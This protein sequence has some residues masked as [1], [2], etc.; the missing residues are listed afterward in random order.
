MDAYDKFEEVNSLVK[1]T[2][3]KHKEANVD[4]VVNKG[5]VV[6]A[7]ARALNVHCAMT[8]NMINAE[9][10]LSKKD[11]GLIDQRLITMTSVAEDC[12]MLSWAGINFGD[13]DTYKLQHSIKKLSTLSGGDQIRF[14]GKIMGK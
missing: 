9:Y 7:E 6:T 13:I 2:N 10:G 12:E 3:M 14:V 1:K 8:K 11:Q 5:G 4:T